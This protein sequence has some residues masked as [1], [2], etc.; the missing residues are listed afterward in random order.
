MSTRWGGFLD[1]VDGFDP[2]FFS[3]TPREAARM[4]P[5][6]RLLLEVAWEAL[7]HAGLPADRIAGSRTGVF[8]G[9]G[10]T[11]YAHVSRHCDDYLEH[12]DAYC[13]TGNALSIA[14]NRLSYVLDLHGPS[15]S[16]DTACS[17][18]LVALHL[19]CRACAAA[20]ATWPWSA[21][22]T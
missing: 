16:I 6:Q 7:E 2:Q 15:L 4:D 17:S 22:S 21:A 1:G 11:D 13:G 10:G 3:I 20:N 12:I 8:V 18:S 9:I 14:A 19:A 5:Q